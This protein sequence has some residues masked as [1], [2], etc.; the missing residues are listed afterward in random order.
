MLK[1][2]LFACVAVMLMI[3]GGQLM[4]AQDQA[5][6][7]G[8]GGAGGGRGGRGG[9]GGAAMDPAAMMQ[10]QLDGIKTATGLDDAGFEAIKAKVQAVL[11]AME[12]LK[13]SGGHCPL[14]H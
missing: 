9:R 14:A 10:M 12:Q 8:P 11:E 2:T 13:Q 3:A 7:G 4:L 1:R 6:A 5:P